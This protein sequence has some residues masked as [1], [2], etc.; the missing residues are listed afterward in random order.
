MAALRPRHLRRYRQI[1]EVLTRHG[2]GALVTQLGLGQQLDLPRRLLRQKP[3]EYGQL[4]PAEHT[5]L[6][7]EELGP[8]F[9]KVGQLL[10]TRSDLLPPSFIS[11]LSRLQ[12]DVPPVSFEQAKAVVEDE[13]DAPIDQIFKTFEER[14]IAAASLGQ[15]HGA[16]LANGED[17]VV[18]I[19]RPN[20]EQVINLDLDILLDL[21][22]LAQVRTPLGKRY[23]VVD[24]T[25]EFAH[26]LKTELDYQREGR[27]ADRFRANFA[28]EAHMYVP[29]VYWE[30]TTKRV[31][32]QERIRGI[33]IDNLEA[34]EAAGYDRKQLA[35]HAAKFILKEI[36]EDG[37]FHADPHPG[38]VVALPNHV[39]GLVD[40]GTV[41]RLATRDRANLVR[42][43]I[44]AVQ[45]DTD[46]VLD[47][48]V[49]MGI[50][51]YSMDYDSLRRD[52]HRLL[53]RYYGVALK[54]VSAGEVLEDLEPIIYRHQLRI[55][56]DLWLLIKTLVI[57]EGV[58]HNLDPDFDIFEFSKP[59]IGSFMRRLWLP[60]EWG[61]A[62]MRSAWNLG[63]LLIDL[64]RQTTR[65]LGQVERGDLGF[66]IHVPEL[67]R[68]TNRLND[69]AN[70][71]I[72]AVLLAAL[73]L[74]LAIII[75][76]LDLIWP[77]NAVTWIAILTFV[78]MCFLAVS[79]V[80]S[81]FRS[82][83]RSK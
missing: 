16:T 17:V 26:S 77:W 53:L 10:S 2:F 24:L 56:S 59:Y 66:Q 28:D 64:P 57:M 18:K 42:L 9:I 47:Q 44:M 78:V 45:L 8:T 19:Q 62:A 40:F 49:R 6:A 58:G 48:L 61:P 11:E 73:I 37:F 39:I 46:G 4:T 3:P 30:Y 20:I 79:L 23:E 34:L 38:N 82:V 21:A 7:L 69:I 60:S 25:E 13:L 32:V 43:F 71:I 81:I 12:D 50:A 36:L 14:P 1:A 41:G 68:T 83:R 31:M 51:D 15:V 70:R 76:N 67:D 80:W 22:Q 52:L 54:E 63:D 35:L 29:K 33:K 27:N 74:G 65:I 5:R 75:P 55:P 72:L